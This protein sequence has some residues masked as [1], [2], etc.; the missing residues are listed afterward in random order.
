M[1]LERQPGMTDAEWKCYRAYWHALRYDVFRKLEFKDPQLR[2]ILFASYVLNIPNMMNYV[3]ARGLSFRKYIH[4]IR[5]ELLKS[6]D[7]C[8]RK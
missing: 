1:K 5:H 2:T 6:R 3:A 4:G 7:I 8:K